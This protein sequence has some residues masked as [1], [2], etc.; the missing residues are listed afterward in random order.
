MKTWFL[1][2]SRLTMFYTVFFAQLE[3][4]THFLNAGSKQ[5]Y[6]RPIII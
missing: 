1:F 6:V 5:V 3:F 2:A 4:S